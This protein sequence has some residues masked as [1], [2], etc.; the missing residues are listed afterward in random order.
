MPHLHQTMLGIPV[1][2]VHLL[3]GRSPQ[4]GVGSAYRSLPVKGRLQG[5]LG[6]SCCFLMPLSD[7]LNNLKCQGWARGAK[8]QALSWQPLSGPSSDLKNPQGCCQSQLQERGE[9][10][11]RPPQRALLGVEDPAHAADSTYD[12]GI[13]SLALSSGHGI[14]GHLLP[15]GREGTGAVKCHIL[16]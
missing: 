3:K 14:P 7:L 8:D 10:H 9:L 16:G 13:H 6:S 2:L 4:I 5:M 11:S 12:T 15:R 1:G